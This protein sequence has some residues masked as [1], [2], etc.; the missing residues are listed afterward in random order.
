MGIKSPFICEIAPDTY[1]IN[2]FG[3][4]TMYLLI[5]EK[6]ALLIDTGCGICDLKQVVAGLTDKPCK[7]A[8]THGHM[9]HVGGMGSFQEV[10]LNEKDYDL[11]RA[12][13]YEEL[14]SYADT[15][16]KAGSY[17][18]YEYSADD[19]PEQIKMPRFLPLKDKARFDLGGRVVE[20]H[21]IAGHTQGGCVFLDV[22]CRLMFSG[23]CCNVNLLAPDCSVEKTLM[24]VRK[25]KALSERFDQN[26]N[27][28][29]GYVGM[30]TCI[31]QPKSVPDDLIYICET[32]L[33]G[34]GIPQPYEFLGHHFM[35]MSYGNARLSYDPELLEEKYGETQSKGGKADVDKGC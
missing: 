1:A 26:F 7:V 15:F 33:S 11:A 14:R 16:G 23:D 28:H 12:L 21:E 6:E 19:V 4:A 17:Q 27:G 24:E 20:V 32:I 13:N 30:P 35:E 31:S 10:Y 8:I 5:G 34:E 3:L 22:A 29:V 18:V 9:D 2:E 25:F